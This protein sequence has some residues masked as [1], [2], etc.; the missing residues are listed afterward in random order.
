M[1]TR[2]SWSAPQLVGQ[3]GPP[4]NNSSLLLCTGSQFLILAHDY[5]SW[6]HWSS[7]MHKQFKTC[8][9]GCYAS[10]QFSHQITFEA[11]VHHSNP[12]PG[13]WL[14]SGLPPTRCWSSRPGPG[15]TSEYNTIL[16]QAF[17]FI[18]FT[19]LIVLKRCNN[20]WWRNMNPDYLLQVFKFGTLPRCWVDHVPLCIFLWGR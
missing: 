2:D 15:Q 14:W 8:R 9:G 3:Q 17:F 20:V 7:W 18:C 5:S 11:L 13:L 6:R 19:S 1:W 16:L 10:E 4:N 12:P